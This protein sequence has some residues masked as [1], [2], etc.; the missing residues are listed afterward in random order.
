MAVIAFSDT[1]LHRQ[2]LL[3][4]TCSRVP[5]QKGRSMA[6]NGGQEELPGTETVVWNDLPSHCLD[7]TNVDVVLCSQ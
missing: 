2:N 3:A 1:A 7:Y 6:K 4:L 5:D